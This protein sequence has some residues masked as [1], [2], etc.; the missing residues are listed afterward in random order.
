MTKSELSRET[1]HYT[2]PVVEERYSGG[3]GANVAANFSALQPA[4]LTMIS[5]LGNDWRGELLVKALKGNN[6]RI[7]DLVISEKRVTPAFSKPFRQ[8]LSDVEYED[9]RLDFLNY[10]EPTPE[11]ES[12]IISNL[13]KV[14]RQV[15]IIA[16]ADQI[17]YG[18]ITGKVRKKLTEIAHSGL[19]VIVDSRDRI[20]LFS[21]IIAKP[22]EIEACR[23]IDSNANPRNISQDKINTAAREISKRNNRPAVITMGSRGALWVEEEKITIIPTISAK[24]PVDICGAGDTFISGFCCAFAAGASGPEAISVANLA[25]GVTIRKIGTT[26]TATRE[27]I[28]KKFE[29]AAGK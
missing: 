15:D 12:R 20:G 8:G 24:P 11:E 3:G 16:V 2:M 19:P 26:G 23:L 10:S 28:L 29:E 9:P 7:S 22:N 17:S 1:P 6:V 18:T 21:G 27:E 13:E 4:S 25:S 14:S 5:I